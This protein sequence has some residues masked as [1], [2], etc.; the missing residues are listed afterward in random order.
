MEEESIEDRI[1]YN[2]TKLVA[3]KIRKTLLN[4]RNI[5]GISARR[6]VWEMVQN[7]KDVPNIFGKVDIKIELTKKS[8]IF[9]HNGS[10]FTIQNVLGILQQVSSKD[11]KNESDQTG[12][13]GTG[14]IGT[15]LLSTKVKIK[16]IVKYKG[17]F[18]R[19]EIMLDRSADSSEELLKE[20]SKSIIDFKNNM[21]DEN[22]KYEYLSFYNQDKTD[23]DTSFEYILQ[24]D[25]S[26]KIA[27]EGIEDLK[28]TA[29]VTMATQCKKISSIFIKNKID[30]EEYKYTIN[31]SKKKEKINFYTATITSTSK[32][33]YKE[34]KKYF[35]SYENRICRLLYQIEKND[36]SYSVV[37]RGENQPILLRDFPLIGSEK[38]HFPFFIDGFKFNP[39][40]TRNGLYLNGNLN[41]EAIEN[42]EI[43]TK[44]IESSIEFTKYIIEQTNN[45]RYLLAKSNIPEPP[46]KYDQCAKEW[47]I[48]QQKEWRKKLIEMNLLKDEENSFNELKTLKLPQFNKKYNKDFYDLLKKIN[49]TGGILPNKEDI[50]IWYDI[51]EKDPLKEVYEIKEDTWGFKYIF[52]E[53]DLFKKIEEYKTINEFANEYQKDTGE[54]LVWLNEL[55][56]FL[57]KNNSFD[58][59]NNHKMIPNQ[60][61]VF[62]NA[63]DIFGNNNKIEDKIP[64]IINQIYKEISKEGK[65]VYDIIVHKDINIKNIDKSIEKK[66]L[67]D[68]FNEFSNFFKDKNN[69]IKKK[70]Y[71]CNEFI[72]FDINNDKIKK[73]F[74][75]RKETQ[76]E[77]EKKKK[78][79]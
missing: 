56:K 19:F 30:N 73:M 44:A 57:N 4:I 68:I 63:H 33:K 47:F 34:E 5:P 49:L 51:M 54:I 29:P 78:K 10:F 15:H 38:F 52:T 23:F 76:P 37:E 16:G 77:Y 55:Y 31:C 79:N 62:L 35:Y 24:D 14:F 13:F 21:N 7:A 3:D 72:C 6:W 71:L 46:Q 59:L 75:F 12:K 39:L 11:S 60:K 32:D 18:R 42:R 25:E 43:L 26:I 74:N 70:E 9:S 45:K 27:K 66:N 1:L 8:L 48:N 58:C 20:I 64:E 50:E 41:H 36:N 65:E 69:D 28:N 61:G 67:K 22:S 53:E 40:E 2:N 17:K